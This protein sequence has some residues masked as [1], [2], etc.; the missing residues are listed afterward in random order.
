MDEKYWKNRSGGMWLENP[1]K[2]TF[3]KREGALDEEALEAF[4][5][6]SRFKFPDVYIAFL[7]KYN[8][9]ETDKS[10]TFYNSNG[11]EVTTTVPLVLPFGQALEKHREMQ[12]EKKGK[13]TFFPVALSPNKFHLFM[14][15]AKGKDCGKIYEYDGLMG[16]M[17]MAFENIEAFFRVLGIEV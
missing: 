15:K 10:F 4:L 12:S 11:T 13:K 2:E 9:L 3:V 5:K 17:P 7:K 1:F 14:I 6:E 16:E 8:G